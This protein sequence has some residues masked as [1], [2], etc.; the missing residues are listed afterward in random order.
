MFIA[1]IQTEKG[2]LRNRLYIF[3]IQNEC[4]NDLVNWFP[5]FTSIYKNK[6]KTE[7]LIIML[8]LLSQ[9]IRHLNK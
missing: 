1:K 5:S 9:I 4:Y 7:I 2:E 8:L 6:G 3:C